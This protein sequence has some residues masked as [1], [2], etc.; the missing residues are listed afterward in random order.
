MKSDGGRQFWKTV[1]LALG[2]WGAT[3][4][5]VTILGATAV[6]IVGARVVLLVLLR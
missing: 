1:R 2:D 6:L 4:R 5:L 3:L